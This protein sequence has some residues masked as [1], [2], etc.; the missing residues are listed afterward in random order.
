[1]N[2]NILPSDRSPILDRIAPI[3]QGVGT[4]TTGWVDVTGLANLM[5]V[6]Q[7]GVLGAAATVDAKLQKAT[8]GAGTGVVDITGKA[9]TQLVKATDDNKQAVIN[10]HTEEI[11]NTFTHVRLSLTVGAAASLVSASRKVR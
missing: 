5:A 1:M 4:V 8:D 9:I 10:L 7:T 6:I 11:G 2:P 3:S